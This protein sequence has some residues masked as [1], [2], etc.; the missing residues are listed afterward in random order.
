MV[1]WRN[2]PQL[3][4][5][6][7]PDPIVLAWVDR[8]IPVPQP[9]APQVSAMPAAEAQ[10]LAV[11]HAGQGFGLPMALLVDEGGAVCSIWRRALRPEDMADFYRPCRG[12]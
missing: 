11:R 12:R 9:L 7:A 4:T 2:L 6:I 3:V 10:A 1:E 8:P 5:A